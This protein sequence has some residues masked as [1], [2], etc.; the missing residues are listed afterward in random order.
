MKNL[1]EITKSGRSILITGDFN[2]DPVRDQDGYFGDS[3]E[4]WK[5]DCDLDQL[6]QTDTRT[7]IVAGKLQT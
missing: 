4:R 6:I 1:H 3:M 2:V 5:N 7:R